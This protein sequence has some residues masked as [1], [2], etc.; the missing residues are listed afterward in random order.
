M[1]KTRTYNFS[2]DEGVD[3]AARVKAAGGPVISPTAAVGE[4]VTHGVHLQ[5]HIAN[6]QITFTL[7]SKPW[8]MPDRMIWS[9]LD[10]LMGEP[11]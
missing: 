4:A 10:G 1:N 5:W 7:V 2:L 3:I 11:I 9:E 6:E 8:V